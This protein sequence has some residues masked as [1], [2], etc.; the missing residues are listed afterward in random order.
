[1]SGS[2]II[3]IIAIGIIFANLNK[4]KKMQEQKRREENPE[5]PKDASY[6]SRNSEPGL[7]KTLNKAMENSRTE[8]DIVKGYTVNREY[9]GKNGDVDPECSSGQILK[10]CGY[11]GALNKIPAKINHP[12][13]CYFCR[14]IL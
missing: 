1:M 3:I 4:Q 13:T 11:C 9:V 10:K 6:F 12:Y 7:T 2:I 8:M 5:K 14:E